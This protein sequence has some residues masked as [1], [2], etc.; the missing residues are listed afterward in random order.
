[1]PVYTQGDVHQIVSQSSERVEAKCGVTAERPSG[2]RL[3]TSFSAWHI[4]VTCVNCLAGI[5]G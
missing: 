1:M 3:S 4:D 2:H 5:R